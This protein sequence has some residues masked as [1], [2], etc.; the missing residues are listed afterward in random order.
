[1][2][3]NG[4]KA[5]VREINAIILE[6]DKVTSI[7]RI[8]KVDGSVTKTLDGFTLAQITEFIAAA[9]EANGNNVLA[10]LMDYKNAHFA[11]FDP[12]AEFTPDW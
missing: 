11:D 5:D 7:T 10:A 1:M 12:M 4:K 9:Q 2:G 6:P 8:K 3:G